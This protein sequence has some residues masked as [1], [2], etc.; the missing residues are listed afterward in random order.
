VTGSVP[1]GKCVAEEVVHVAT[2][3]LPDTVLGAQP[4]FAL[5]LT[6]PVGSIGFIPFLPGFRPFTSP[7][8]PLIVAVNVTDVA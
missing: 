3:G 7:F 5:Q 4:V 6:V 8:A 1:T 2:P